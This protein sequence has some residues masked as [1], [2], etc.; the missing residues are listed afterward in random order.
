MFDLIFRA[1]SSKSSGKS[2]KAASALNVIY[3]IGFSIEDKSK[4]TTD[5]KVRH[6]S[7]MQSLQQAVN[8]NNFLPISYCWFF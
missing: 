5:Y 6:L 2:T 4:K 1:G 7:W 3:V 8:R